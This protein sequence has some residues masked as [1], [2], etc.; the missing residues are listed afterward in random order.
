M[1]SKPGTYVLILQSCRTGK[2]QIG[3]WQEITLH[4]GFYL[5]V[6]SAFGPGGVRARVSR[7]YRTTKQYHWHIDYLR[8]FLIPIGTWY[9]HETTRLEHQWARILLD[10]GGTSPIQGFGCTDCICSSHLLQTSTAPNF[11]LFSNMTDSKVEE[12]TYRPTA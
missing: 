6:G 2:A 5:Y 4:P 1:K 7:H 11:D 8:E 9:S 12:W 3:R 10:M